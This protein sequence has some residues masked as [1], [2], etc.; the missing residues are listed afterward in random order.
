MGK[1]RKASSG[2][3]GPKGPR[4]YDPKDARLGRISS[5]K[6][7]A[8]EQERYFL[9]QDQ[10]IFDD[11]P[12]SKRQKAIEE[13]EAFMEDSDEEILNE[14]YEDS[15]TDSDDEEREDFTQKP[16]KA[17]KRKSGRVAEDE[18]DDEGE[19]GDTGYWGASRKD[20]YN[21]DQIETTVDAEEE[22]R[23]AARLQKKKLAKMSDAD[24][25]DEN[26]WLAPNAGD[27][28][29]NDTVTEVLTKDIEIPSDMGPVERY[30]LLQERHPEFPALADELLRLQPQLVEL[31]RD[32]EGQ[33][34]KSLVVIRYRVLSSY[35]ATLAMYFAIL[36]SPAR[37]GSG[38]AKTLDPAELREHE[39][40]GTLVE[41]RQ[42]WEKVEQLK[43][44]NKAQAAGSLPSP[45]EDNIVAIDEEE[46]HA[47]KVIKET[48]KEKRQK[49]KAARKAQAIE[50][51]LAD[52]DALTAPKKTKKKAVIKKTE[53]DSHS[54][55]GEEETLDA[56]AA[57]E[58]AARKKSL[59]FYTS[60]IVQKANRRAEAGRDV[61]GDLDIPY[62][63]RLKDRQARLNAQAEKRG[64]NSSLGADLGDESGGDDDDVAAADVRNAADAEYYNTVAAASHKKKAD[65]ASRAAALAAAGDRIVEELNEDGTRRQ[66][67]WTIEKNKGLAPKRRKE[68]RN[69]RVKKRKQYDTKKKKLASQ[70]AIYKGGEG[71]GGYGGELSGLKTNLVKSIKL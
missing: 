67:G 59:R 51:S 54:D 57:D 11:G 5:Y 12:K 37:D 58:K 50:D 68:N 19:E 56:R 31:Q 13:D 2:P 48:N 47:P 52:L 28:D 30:R 25:F 55:F 32:A 49:A 61:G 6:D 15:D 40:V 45:P 14:N 46:D 41:C 71:R 3:S 39:V 38:A 9:D 17:D 44:S 36:T 20:Y 4:E 8:D 26:E 70:K 53:D 33:D 1:K 60:Q 10:I 18:E 29:Q 63:E 34:S 24:F 66:I 21:A 16:T 69:S 22:E 43:A 7:I 35:V 65:K 64:K 23:E 27:E 42:A 62:R